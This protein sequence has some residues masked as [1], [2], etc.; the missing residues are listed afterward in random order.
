MSNAYV[1]DKSEKLFE[2]VEDVKRLLILM[3]IRNGVNQRQ[4]AAALNISQSSVSRLF[5]GGIGR[6]ITSRNESE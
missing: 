4:I 1:D 3:L 2:S 5:K 6:L